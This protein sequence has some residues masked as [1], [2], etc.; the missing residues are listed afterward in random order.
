[1]SKTDEDFR[2]V[3]AFSPLPQPLRIGKCS[4]SDY[5]VAEAESQG[6]LPA[7]GAGDKAPKE[8]VDLGRL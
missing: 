4:N 3:A 7:A 1:M 6:L 5:G 2:D 8:E